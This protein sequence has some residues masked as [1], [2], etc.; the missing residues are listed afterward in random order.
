MRGFVKRLPE[1]DAKGEFVLL[2]PLMACCLADAVA[3]GVRATTTD[4]MLPDDEEWV[5]VFGALSE[6]QEPV[7]T[8]KIRVGPDRPHPSHYGYG[9]SIQADGSFGHTGSDGTA[10]CAEPAKSHDSGRYAGDHSG[11]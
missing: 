2:Q 10:V 8:P 5:H 11:L 3:L 7:A 4:G 9:F 1:L 6:R